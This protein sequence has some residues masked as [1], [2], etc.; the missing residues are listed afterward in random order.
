MMRLFLCILFFHFSTYGQ[1]L[2]HELQIYLEENY[3]LDDNDLEKLYEWIEKPLNLNACYVHQLT[4]LPFVTNAQAKAIIEYR[5]E[6]KGFQSIYELQAI[7]ELDLKTIELLV[8]FVKVGQLHKKSISKN[9][10]ILAFIENKK[11]EKKSIKALSQI[12][13]NYRKTNFWNN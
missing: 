10:R 3:S 2:P 5:E 4:Q 11:L 12:Q 9:S 13:T 8:P 1:E 7:I 6:K